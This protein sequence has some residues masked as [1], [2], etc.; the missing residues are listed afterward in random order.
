ML[1]II[2]NSII[3]VTLEPVIG[4]LVFWDRTI[5][6]HPP[7]TVIHT[8]PLDTSNVAIE[9]PNLFTTDSGRL[10]YKLTCDIQYDVINMEHIIIY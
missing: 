8:C 1:F 2:P 4:I 5:S 9:W 3:K 10:I 7:V 6:L